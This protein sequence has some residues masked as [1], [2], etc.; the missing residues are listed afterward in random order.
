MREL[1]EIVSRSIG[2]LHLIYRQYKRETGKQFDF[3]EMIAWLGDRECVKIDGDLM[4]GEGD[5][6]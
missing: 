6:K 4:E 5:K 2:N 1:K 3:N